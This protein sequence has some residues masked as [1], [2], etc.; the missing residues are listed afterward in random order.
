M[1]Y[2]VKDI[3]S[4]SGV[5][6]KTLHHYHKIGLLLPCAVSEAGYRLYGM[7][8]LERLQ[9]ILFYRELDFPLKEIARLLEEEPERHS[10]LAQQ[11]ELLL[12][13]KQRLE[14]I[15]QTLQQSMA[16]MEKGE[17]MN[18]KD[19]FKGFENAQEWEKALE[20][21]NRHLKDAYGYDM[22]DSAEIDAQNMNEQAQEAAAFMNHIAE[23]LRTGIKHSDAEIQR[24]I[25]EHL[26]FMNKH[27]HTV[28]A[29]DFAAQARFFLGDDFHLRMLEGQQ[30]GL[31]YYLS[32][33]AESYAAAEQQ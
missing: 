2:T 25:Q 7:K 4:L 13:R 15:I 14:T 27:G 16:S 17:I 26:D 28:T 5:T 18:S 12:V 23:A 24:L 30:T 9:H 32:A 31:A 3:S 20:E 33:A 21:Q 1:L 22:L 10:I 8:E 19:M 6:V 11:E 29:T